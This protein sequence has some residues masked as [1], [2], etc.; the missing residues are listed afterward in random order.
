MNTKNIVSSI[1]I[2]VIVVFL[3]FTIFG[4]KTETVIEKTVQPVGVAAGPL[5][6]EYQE[7][8]DNMVVGGEVFATSSIGTATYTAANLYKKS[9]IQHTAASALTATLPAS[10]TISWIPRAGDKAVIF[11]NPITTGI[12][13]AGGTGTELNTASSTK[14][15]VANQLARLEFVRKINSD[16]EVFMTSSSGN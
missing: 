2:S 16:I 6:T 5:H 8:L 14:F 15:V 9:L 11:L 10:S 4:G 7:F 13:L 12:T 3:G 1:V